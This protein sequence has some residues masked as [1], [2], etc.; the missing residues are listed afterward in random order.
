MT[1]CACMGPVRGEP[2]CPC[3]MIQMGLKT[4]NDYKMSFE[5][6]SALLTAMETIFKRNSNER[7]TRQ[8]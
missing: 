7:T 4:E 1:L 8:D 2:H 5:E 3:V 6:E